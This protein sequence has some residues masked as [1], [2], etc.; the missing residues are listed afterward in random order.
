MSLNYVILIDKKK[1]I[2]IVTVEEPR[3]GVSHCISESM[4]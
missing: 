1:I 3:L 4:S 2:K